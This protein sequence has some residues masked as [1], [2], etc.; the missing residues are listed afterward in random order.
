MRT[1]NG[2]T[3]TYSCIQG[4]QGP[5]GEAGPTGPAGPQ[6]EGGIGIYSVEVSY[7]VTDS[8][9]IIPDDDE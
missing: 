1:S 4:A 8:E 2:S 3:Y 6:G 7:A 5:R 9:D